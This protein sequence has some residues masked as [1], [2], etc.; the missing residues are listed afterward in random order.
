MTEGD[1]I[2]LENGDFFVM[3]SGD[4]FNWI[5]QLIQLMGQLI[6]YNSQKRI[7]GLK[8]ILRLRF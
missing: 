6:K 8:I 7:G 4:Q 3:E 1:H 5:F 2:A